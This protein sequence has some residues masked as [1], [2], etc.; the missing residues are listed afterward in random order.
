MKTAGI[1]ALSILLVLVHASCTRRGYLCLYNN[2]AQTLV[3]L[4]DNQ[5]WT[6]CPFSK[7]T[8]VLY[9][10]SRT[11]NLISG[12]IT[13]SYTQQYIPLDWFEK[14]CVKAQ[15]ESN[16]Y[17]YVLSPHSRMPVTKHVAQ[18][19]GYPLVPLPR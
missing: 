15:V 12:A 13:N 9:G 10:T 6:I 1:L 5:R 17:I 16:M 19:R 11:L 8:V 3:A 7:E 4:T 2:T 18:P 14:H